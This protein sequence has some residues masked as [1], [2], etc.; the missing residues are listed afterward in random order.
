[1]AP[2]ISID[3]FFS[4]IIHTHAEYGFDLRGSLCYRH[5]TALNMILARHAYLKFEGRELYLSGKQT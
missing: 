4:L 5:I 1:M 2:S 3:H